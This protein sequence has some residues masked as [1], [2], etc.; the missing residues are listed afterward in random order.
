MNPP[1]SLRAA[2]AADVPLILQFIRELAEY[3][4]LLGT[5]EATETRVHEALFG[6][7]PVA[8]CILGY[9]DGHPAGF[10]LFFTNYSTFLAKP[11]IYLEDLFV[12]PAYRR[13]GLG[14]ALL[15][16]L[17]RLANER[18]CGRLEW[19]VLDWNKPAIDFY[20]SLGA[21][22]LPDWRV[23]RLTGEALARFQ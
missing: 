7:R 6:A 12:R 3:E 5:V 16:H 17:A 4:S 22:V 15:C 14:R 19:T 2:V 21:S 8:E 10:A 13:R 18:R 23:C 20:V 1:I 9:A 11:G